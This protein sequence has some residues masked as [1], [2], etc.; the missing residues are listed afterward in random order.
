[1]PPKDYNCNDY[2]DN[3]EDK[4]KA[5]IEYWLEMMGFAS[6]KPK[7][8]PMPEPDLQLITVILYNDM[9]KK[10]KVSFIPSLMFQVNLN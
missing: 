10:K 5:D 7:P 6:R 2:F 9:F 4:F 3:G 1:M 8:K